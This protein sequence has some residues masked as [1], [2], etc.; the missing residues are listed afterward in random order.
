MPLIRAE[1]RHGDNAQYVLTEGQDFF[2]A[3]GIL[4]QSSNALAIF[5]TSPGAHVLRIDGTISGYQ[6]ALLCGVQG[7]AGPAYVH[8]GKTGVLLS[9]PAAPLGYG[10]G[11]QAQGSMLEN[12]GLISAFNAVSLNATAGGPDD[13]IVNR[14]TIFGANSA[15]Y[16][17]PGFGSGSNVQI[18]NTGTI[19]AAYALNFQS[20]PGYVTFVNHGIVRGDLAFGTDGGIYDG[21]HGLLLPGSGAPG[22]A[23]VTTGAGSSFI[24]APGRSAEAF[25]F[26]FAATVFLSFKDG[27]AVR[28]ALDNSFAAAGNAQGDTFLGLAQVRMLE[29]SERGDDHLR[30]MAGNQRLNGLGGNDTLDGMAGDDILDGGKGADQLFG[31][32]GADGLSGGL[33]ADALF[34]GAG[35]DTFYFASTSWQGDRLGDFIAEDQILLDVAP[36]KLAMPGGNRFATADEFRQT[37]GHH[38]AGDR[39]DRFIYDAKKTELWF[40]PDGSGRKKAFLLLDFQPGA[41]LAAE[42]ITLAYFGN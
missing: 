22:P 42:D 29:G 36:L 14:G 28:L 38:R 31:G 18:Y 7:V 4:V 34:G 20:E 33:G 10:I 5:G 3:Q 8:I 11:L 39:S 24:A 21:T 6:G 37:F 13:I 2:L 19:A 9:N 15:F 25:D 23:K 27:P 41:V 1:D 30:A 35:A 40:D 16:R 26:S 32:D 17:H 12:D